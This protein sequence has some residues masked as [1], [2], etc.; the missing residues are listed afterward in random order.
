MYLRSLSLR[1]FRS[2]PEL[3]LELEPGITVFTGRNGYG[4]TKLAAEQLARAMRAQHGI[5]VVIARA[6][7]HAGPRQSPRMMLSQWAAQFAEPG[8]PVEIHT[9]DELTRVIAA[10]TNLVGVNNR[11]LSTLDVDMHTTEEIGPAV[12]SGIFFVSESGIASID[13]ARRAAAAGAS[14]LLVGEALVRCPHERLPDL[15]HQLRTVRRAS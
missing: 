1:D 9:R 4:K 6:F 5:D 2:W 8:R 7:Q 13:D 3:S 15:V 14:A 10:R 11:N 12:P